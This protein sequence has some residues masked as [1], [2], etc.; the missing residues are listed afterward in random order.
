MTSGDDVHRLRGEGWSIRGIAAALGLSRMKV[1]RLLTEDTYP[2]DDTN[3]DADPWDDDDDEALS[4]Y[5][6]A[7]DR[8]PVEPFT[9][10][11]TERQYFERG[12]GMGG[13]W[14]DC[15]R[16]VDGDGH[17]IGGEHESA[18]MALFRYRGHVA[19]EL[20]EYERAD[21]LQADWQRQ[22]DEYEARHR[23]QPSADRPQHI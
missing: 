16:W 15:E 19:N 12:K 17:S 10:V 6:E 22:R 18:E 8:W 21:A 20:G 14:A 11:G 23:P 3:T 2:E 9:Y 4:L 5:D 7:E 13:Y 1:H